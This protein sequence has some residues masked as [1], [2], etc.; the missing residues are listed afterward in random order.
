VFNCKWR[1]RE[2]REKL[3]EVFLEV[4][5][6]FILTLIISGPTILY[7][8]GKPQLPRQHASCSFSVSFEE[9]GHEEK[10]RGP[11]EWRC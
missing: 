7:N 9:V 6:S 11:L 1:A 8:V 2:Y 3:H 5:Y 4:A 10:S